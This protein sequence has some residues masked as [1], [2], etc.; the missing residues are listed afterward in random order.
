M[1]IKSRD[2][3]E[4]QSQLM[5]NMNYEVIKWFGGIFPNCDSCASG[6]IS[7]ATHIATYD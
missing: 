5:T 1:K 7:K 3:N 2:A 4:A 6:K